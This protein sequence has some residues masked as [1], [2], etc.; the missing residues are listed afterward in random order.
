MLSVNK[1]VRIISLFTLLTSLSPAQTTIVFQGFEGGASDNWGFIPPFQ[2][3]AAG[4]VIVGA[5]VYAGYAKTGSGSMRV[6]GGS[7]GCGSGSANCINGSASGGGCTNAFNGS[8]VQ[9][10]AVNVECLSGVQLSVSHRSH[11]LC[12]GQGQGFDS[13]ENLFFEVSINGGVWTTVGTLGGFSNYS[14]T[15]ATTPAGSGSTVANPFIYNVPAGTVTVAFRTRSTINRADEVYY[16]DDVKLTTTTTGYIFPG[17]AG[18]WNGVVNT[19]WT[20][21]CNWE[22]RTVPTSAV[23]VVIPAAALNICEVLPAVTANCR[24][25]VIDKS[26]LSAEYF[27]S[28]LNVAG[29]LT[30]DNNGELDM[31]LA[32]NEGGTLNLGGNWLNKRDETFF[33]EGKSTVNF[34]GTTNQ[35]INITGDTKE[36]FYKSN[37]NKISGNVIAGKDIW[38]DKDIL[39]GTSNMLV[40][41]DGLL[42]LNA[43]KL[44]IWNP[45]FQALTR[46]GGGIIS[47]RTDNA[48][49]V[50]W[51]MNSNTGSYLFPFSLANGIYIP[52]T[53]NHTAGNA[54]DVSVSTYPTP[55]DNLPW[56]TTPVAVTNLNSST[57]LTPDNRDATVDRFWQIDVSGSATAN[58]TFYYAA[59]ELPASPY[60]STGSM[61]A[62]RFTTSTNKWLSYLPGQSAGVNFVTVPSVTAFSP[63]TLTNQTSPLP[64]ELLY[65]DAKAVKKQVEVSWQTV[66]ELNNDYFT[67]QRSQSNFDFEDIGFVNGAGNSNSLLNYKF[68]D[69]NPY[70]G[71]SYYRLKQTDFNGQF[72][73]SKSVPVNIRSTTSVLII[74]YVYADNDNST[75]NAYIQISELRQ[76]Q[77]ALINVLGQTVVSKELLPQDKQLTVSLST[78]GLSEGVYF[79]RVRDE[80]NTESKKVV[81]Y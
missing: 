80:S 36:V 61:R 60:N 28:T 59:A 77:V 46:S 19:D 47:E 38:I 33:K 70:N 27:T 37:I 6:A 40:I 76:M 26:K 15:Y 79:L 23:D 64:I 24:N 65:F 72:S 54:G 44:V 73:L 49:K 39:G 34:V 22:N 57:G 81:I 48:S 71:I 43:H 12:V 31:S 17:T 52:F 18:I 8:S 78:D 74:E 51:K 21:K 35:T 68:T 13:G 5:G 32:G 25:I 16:V 14:W 11:A 3:P 30:I 2:N 50:I 45:N 66:S 63:W 75:V 69:T 41:Y 7:T 29:N 58:L 4:Q 56:P 53:F 1:V 9:F 62:Q 10:N 55:P 42:D 67:V 20:N